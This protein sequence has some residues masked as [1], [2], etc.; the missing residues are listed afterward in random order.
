MKF[1]S[2]LVLCLC[3]LLLKGQ[4]ISSAHP[5]LK[6]LDTIPLA[7][8]ISSLTDTLME[9]R[10]SGTVGNVLAGVYIS[11]CFKKYGLSYFT[12]D[13]WFQLFPVDS[14]VIG[15]NIVGMIRGNSRPQE[16]IVVSA[17][18]DHLGRIQ[19]AIY[20]GADDNAS[21]VAVLLQMAEMFG[22]RLREGRGPSRSI[23]F[24][25]YDAK[26]RD[27]AGSAYF[28]GSLGI[29]P[30]Q[31][32]ANLNIDQIGCVL[33]PPHRNERYVLVLGAQRKTDDLALVMDVANRYNRLELD[34]DY[35]FYGSENF[36]KLFFTIGDQ[37]HLDK[38]GVP[39]ILYTSG[40]HA[41][42]YKTTDVPA[43]IRYDVLLQRSKLLY[44]TI[45]DLISRVSWLRQKRH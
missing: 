36:S 31:I 39:S 45:D 13:S 30:K 26:E 20:P 12:G 9:G 23:I 8:H 25:A 17:H 7:I 37:V 10:A 33:E 18:Y 3:P 4:F 34:I 43:L 41:Y 15:R 19:G 2:C 28:A 22:K 24:V 16:Y 21:G 38:L 40:I 29:S 42:T 35:S 27:L 5:D 11:H 6:A 1:L 32:M 44:L 14:S